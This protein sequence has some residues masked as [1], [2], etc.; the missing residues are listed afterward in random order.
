MLTN[1]L[2][3]LRDLRAPLAAE[4]LWLAAGWLYFAPQLP[5]SVDDAQGV[6]KDIYRVV[7][8][9]DH[10]AV[11]AGLTFVAYIVG[12]LSAGLLTPFFR[13]IGRLPRFILTIPIVIAIFRSE[14]LSTRSPIESNADNFLAASRIARWHFKTSRSLPIRAERF[15]LRRMSNKVL[16]D[17][18]YRGIFLTRLEERLNNIIFRASTTMGSGALRRLQFV[19]DL[20][21]NP[22]IDNK[23]KPSKILERLSEYLDEGYLE[24]G[25]NLVDSVVNVSRHAQDILEELTLVPERLVGDRPATYERWDRLRAESEF[26]Q[27]VVPPLLAIIGVLL[28]RGVLSW[29]SMLLFVVPPVLIL[30]QG[31]SKDDEADGQLMQALEANVI[32]TPAIDRL[33]TRD[34]YWFRSADHW[35]VLFPGEPFRP[36]PDDGS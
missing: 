27:A 23:E 18:D 15:A 29:P 16:I 12:I 14:V 7:D 21:D 34:L 17:N 11:A 22:S 20:I 28:V 26:R 19:R 1:L 35:G 32:S 33:A 8:R 13:F 10:V 30:I 5:A 24:A 6:L 25:D 36:D 3:G 2:P 4:Y 9:S 31:T